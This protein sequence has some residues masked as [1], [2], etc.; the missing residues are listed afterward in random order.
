MPLLIGTSPNQVPTNAD[1]GSMAFQDAESVNI[2]S[3]YVAG[4]PSMRVVVTGTT[5]TASAGQHLILTNAGATTVTLP[6]TPNALDTIQITVANDRVDNVVS[7]NSKTIDGSDN[8]LTIPSKNSSFTL[9]YVNDT[10][11]WRTGNTGLNAPP[12]KQVYSI[13]QSTLFTSIYNSMDNF[14][15]YLLCAAN[16]QGTVTVQLNRVNADGSIS[17][18]T[19][20]TF[21]ALDT[22][23]YKLAV[24]MLSETVGC[25]VYPN[26]SPGCIELRS[27]ALNTSNLTI[28][29]NSSPSSLGNNF[30]ED[31]AGGVKLTSQRLLL[32]Y[33]DT[34]GYRAFVGIS[35]NADGTAAAAYT[36]MNTTSLHVN[37]LYSINSTQA[38]TFDSYGRLIL[39]T[40]S[41]SA[42]PT[43]SALNYVT[44]IP[45][46]KYHVS[47][48][49]CQTLY[50]NTSPYMA[51]TNAKTS[52]PGSFSGNLPSTLY[53]FPGSHR[54]YADDKVMIYVVD[55]VTYYCPLYLASYISPVAYFP[56]GEHIP[57]VGSGNIGT[58]V[59]MVGR[60]S[61]GGGK[62]GCAIDIGA[63]RYYILSPADGGVQVYIYAYK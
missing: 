23:G 24:F 5:V 31:V 55:G 43:E 8:D 53:N 63:V 52:M 27:I 37:T 9:T 10:I 2:K 21:S 58:S 39:V 57:V 15:R 11:Q 38:I 34:S 32:A 1:L 25:I 17:F 50:Q 49:Y 41:G 51:Q 54:A 40:F 13:G 36:L 20:Q 22:T 48:T 46:S 56:T 60:Q 14:G 45:M 47:D 62:F 6:S 16:N 61:V 4:L 18:G 30:F 12:Q 44:G 35:L 59:N 33:Q 29:V 3:G 7:R 42:K 26:S 28:T 19:A